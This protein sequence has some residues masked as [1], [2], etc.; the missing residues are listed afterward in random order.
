MGESRKGRDSSAK[1]LEG[2]VMRR[3]RREGVEKRKDMEGMSQDLPEASDESV[4]GDAGRTS[5]CNARCVGR[6]INIHDDIL[7]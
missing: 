5:P 6:V 7:S 1:E 3:G 4:Q 2:E